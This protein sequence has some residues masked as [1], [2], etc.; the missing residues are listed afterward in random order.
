[1]REKNHIAFIIKKEV[2][3]KFCLQVRRKGA[4]LQYNFASANKLYV[5]IFDLWLC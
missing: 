2:M 3:M 1:M 5:L 4:R